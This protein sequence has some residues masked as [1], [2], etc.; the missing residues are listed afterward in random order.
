MDLEFTIQTIS[1]IAHANY[2]QAAVTPLDWKS[3]YTPAV[4]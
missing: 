2:R 1:Y 3:Y 4:V